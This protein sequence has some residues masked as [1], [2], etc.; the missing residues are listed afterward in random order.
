MHLDWFVFFC[1]IVNLL[2]LVYFL[3]RFLYGRII[4][5]MDTREAKIASIF[6]DG[7]GDAGSTTRRAG[8][9]TAAAP[10]EFPFPEAEARNSLSAT[11]SIA[12]D[13]DVA[14][15]SRGS[16]ANS[17][18]ASSAAAAGAR[19]LPAEETRI[20]F[21]GGATSIVVDCDGAACSRA[22]SG[23]IAVTST[24]AGLLSACLDFTAAS[25]DA[26]SRS[27]RS[28]GAAGRPDG[29]CSRTRFSSSA[30]PDINSCLSKEAFIRLSSSLFSARATQNTLTR[31]A[32]RLP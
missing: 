17:A 12:T 1:Q 8:F 19:S 18:A 10:G 28:L 27:R 23:A 4:K 24:A 13:P 7:E 20:S 2:I 5:A 22:S 25:I 3:K 6:A 14:V 9:L 29:R 15:C 26:R 16:A 11:R 32:A 30:R 21:S 31:G